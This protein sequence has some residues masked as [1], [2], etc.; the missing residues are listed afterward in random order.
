MQSY[1]DTRASY[2][3]SLYAM[4]AATGQNVAG[5]AH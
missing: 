4:E 3:R 1:N 5:V 2:A